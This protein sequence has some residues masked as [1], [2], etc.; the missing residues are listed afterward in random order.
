[1]NEWI[2][3]GRIRTRG[4]IELKIPALLNLKWEK[5]SAQNFIALLNQCRRAVSMHAYV[6]WEVPDYTSRH[7]PVRLP[8][9]FFPRGNNFLFREIL[10]RQ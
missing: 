7:F 6:L 8:T 9:T 3:L 5:E 4:A 2:E 10:L 1:M